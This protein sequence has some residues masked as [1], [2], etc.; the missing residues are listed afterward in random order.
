MKKCNKCNESKE[1]SLFGK[2]KGM[3][4]GYLNTCKSCKAA[5]DKQRRQEKQKEISDKAKAYYQANKKMYQEKHRARYQQNREKYLQKV[6]AYAVENKEA[7]LQK[8]K[9]YYED[10]KNSTKYKDAREKYRTSTRGRI[11]KRAS[12]G[13]RRAAVKSSSDNTITAQAL[14]DL[15]KTQGN[16]CKYCG[17]TL[18]F[19]EKG[20]VHLDHVVPLSKGGPHSITN[21]VWSCAKCNLT[22]SDKHLKNVKH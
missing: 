4:D 3:T 8:Q 21:V 13:K 19:S 11:A 17:T 22:K 2:H 10:N 20:T 15:R 16:K 6:K 14:E 7:I 5:Y 18:D 9:K 1:L 12:E